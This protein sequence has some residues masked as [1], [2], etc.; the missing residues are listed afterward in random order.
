MELQAVVT[1]SRSCSSAVVTELDP[2][3]INA[4]VLVW[5]EFA[6]QE[7]VNIR[8]GRQ[9]LANH[10]VVPPGK[11]TDRVALQ[12]LRGDLHTTTVNG[13]H[14]VERTDAFNTSMEQAVHLAGDGHGHTAQQAAARA[15]CARRVGPSFESG[16]VRIANAI[17]AVRWRGARRRLPLSL[18]HFPAVI[19]IHSPVVT[20]RR[21]RLAR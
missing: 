8:E 21:Q 18:H 11:S 16:V 3:M 7:L 20:R 15:M 9:D 14:H 6:C 13:L 19:P 10:A 1:C 2:V 5:R 17:A 4:S 12:S